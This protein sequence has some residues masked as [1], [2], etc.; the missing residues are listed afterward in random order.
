MRKYRKSLS[1]KG[2]PLSATILFELSFGVD[3]HQGG[4]ATIHARLE[5]EDPQAWARCGVT[6]PALEAE[7]DFEINTAGTQEQIQKYIQ[8]IEK[9]AQ[10]DLNKLSAQAAIGSGFAGDVEAIFAAGKY[11]EI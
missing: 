3:S 7:H 9:A 6:P 11:Q 1:V 2:F 5:I 8:S 10:A 4:I